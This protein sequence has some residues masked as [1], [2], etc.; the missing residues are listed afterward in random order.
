MA[1][2]SPPTVDVHESFLA[3]MAEFQAEGRGYLE[4]R[5]MIGS[6]I[7]TYGRSWS[8]PEVFTEYVRW[9]RAQALESST[10][11]NGW[12]PSTTLW[13]VDGVHFLGRIAIR[14]WL[15]A[16]LR[17]LGGHIGYDVRPSARRLGHAT[18]M[19]HAALPVAHE[20]GI[21]QALI[22]C[23]EDNVAS[24]KVIERNGGVFEN[25]IDNKLRFWTPALQPDD[26]ANP[27]SAG[28]ERHA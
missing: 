6:E 28:Q 8:S 17:R 14:H 13:W 25:K 1:Q 22:T 15:N 3:A 20:L 2:L 27:R 5:S 11:P 12:V 18:A 24:R 4:D 9:L 23:D 10:R 16:H 26:P 7:R 21:E 19:L